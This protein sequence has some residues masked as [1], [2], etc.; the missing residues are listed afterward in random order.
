MQEKKL[1]QIL[2]STEQINSTVSR[3]E[4]IVDDGEY[5]PFKEAKRYVNML[6]IKSE[7]DWHQH[8]IIK[9]KL[10]VNIPKYPHI[11]YSSN[12]NKEGW[13][14]WSDWLG[15]KPIKIRSF[16][17]TKEF[18]QKMNINNNHEW[19][20]AIN[21]GMLPA[22][23]PRKPQIEYKKQW[24]GLNNFFKKNYEKL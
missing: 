2:E 10:P 4:F 16:K 1:T 24:K 14:S 7:K 9:N 15:V 19:V 13:V 12:E 5:L 20:K 22:D 6:M 18:L 11:E 3:M 17:E 23:I 8:A 21:S